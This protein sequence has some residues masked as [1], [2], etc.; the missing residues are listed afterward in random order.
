[1]FE[2][3]EYKMLDATDNYIIVA[4]NSVNELLKILNGETNEWI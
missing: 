1:M 3:L 4:W 2:K